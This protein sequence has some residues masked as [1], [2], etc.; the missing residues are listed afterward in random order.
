[1]FV[2]SQ[3]LAQ[4]E[5]LVPATD[6]LYPY[7]MGG[8]VGGR[9]WDPDKRLPC[10]LPPW[11][12]LYAVNV[13]T[14]KVAWKVKLGVTDSFPAALQNTGRPNIGGSIAT[15]GGLVFI[16]ATDDARFRALM[17]RLVPSC[18]SRSLGP[19]PTPSHPPTR[20]QTASSMS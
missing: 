2:K 19:Q 5:G 3:D 18:G 11:G 17:P 8:S 15:A 12:N 4:L 7:R 10:Q 13:K 20:H 1:M 9:F 14:G 6:G 16:G